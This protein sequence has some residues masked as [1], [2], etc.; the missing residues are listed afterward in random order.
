MRSSLVVSGDE[1]GEVG[2]LSNAAVVLM[3]IPK[4]AVLLGHGHGVQ[5]GGVA[6]G[7]EVAADDEEVDAIPSALLGRFFGGGVDGVEC[8]VALFVC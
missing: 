1:Y 8:A 3:E 2:C 5:V 4:L 6:D 7:L